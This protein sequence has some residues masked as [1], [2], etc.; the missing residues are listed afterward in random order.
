MLYKNSIYPYPNCIGGFGGGGDKGELWRRIAFAMHVFSFRKVDLQLKNCR[1]L[2]PVDRNL[3]DLHGWRAALL[4]D[5]VI[6]LSEFNTK[7]DEL[8]V[9]DRYCL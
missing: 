2:S 9:V 4:I 6:I 5:Y 3:C 1:H 7:Q 8:T